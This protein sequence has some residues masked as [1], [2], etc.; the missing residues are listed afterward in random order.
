MGTRVQDVR[1]DIRRWRLCA[2]FV[3]VTLL[4]LDVGAN[5]LLGGASNLSEQVSGWRE[6]VL[7]TWT[8]AATLDPRSE[9]LAGVAEQLSADGERE[10]PVPWDWCLQDAGSDFR[11]WLSASTA[12]A[13]A[14][15]ATVKALVELGT[16]DP[17]LRG[18]FDRL[19]RQFSSAEPRRR[20]DLYLRA[21]ALR[22]EIRLRDLRRQYPQWIFTKH[23]DLG[24]SHYAYTEGQSD[25]QAERHFEPGAACACWRWTAPTAPRP[26]A[27]GRPQRRDPRPGRLVR[28][29]ARPVR[30]EEVRPTRTTTI[31]TRWTLGRRPASGSS[32]P[33]WAS[34]T[35]RA[36]ICP[37]ATSSS[38]RPAACRR[39]IAGGP[40]SATSTP[41]TATAAT[42]AG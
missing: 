23:Y 8:Q 32:P 9:G 13:V 40:R 35:T 14:Q 31:S 20:L 3:A 11:P 17:N 41:A 24:G 2:G 5:T 16:A 10:F 18:E 22:R 33:A 4:T 12:S 39:S 1:C 42:C 26:H 29:P 7:E 25:A 27:A 6:A 38:T 15:A 36:S 28:R 34:P 30:L 21:A 19:T 37:T